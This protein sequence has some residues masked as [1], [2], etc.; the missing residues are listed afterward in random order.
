MFNESYSTQLQNN[1]GMV[2]KRL[3]HIQE[4][5]VQRAMR[6]RLNMRKTIW[7]TNNKKP[8]NSETDLLI[9]HTRS[10]NEKFEK[11]KTPKYLGPEIIGTRG[12]GSRIRKKVIGVSVIELRLSINEHRRISTY[13]RRSRQLN[14]PR[15]AAHTDNPCGARAKPWHAHTQTRANTHKN[16][17]QSAKHVHGG[18]NIVTNEKT[19][20]PASGRS[21]ASR[22]VRGR[23][24]QWRHTL[25]HLRLIPQS[26]MFVKCR[27]C[28]YR[29]HRRDRCQGGKAW[30]LHTHAVPR[31]G[32]THRFVR[33]WPFFFLTETSRRPTRPANGRTDTNRRARTRTSRTSTETRRKNS[34]DGESRAMPVPVR[35]R[36]EIDGAATSGSCARGYARGIDRV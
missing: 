1:Y 20:S 21:F 13:A 23:A 19:K 15:A 12:G 27:R 22:S 18:T 6:I 11:N 14:P 4:L 35:C 36:T 17:E 7:I 33:P 16:K 9:K 3:N 34:G 31:R 29:S 28:R 32:G 30:S 10:L 24:M 5:N 2:A 26:I 8:R 25:G